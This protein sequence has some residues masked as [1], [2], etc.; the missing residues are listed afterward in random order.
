VI[1]FG[2]DGLSSYRNELLLQFAYSFWKG[3]DIL[4]KQQ[5]Q[6]EQEQQQQQQLNP[7]IY[8]PVE[9]LLSSNTGETETLG[10]FI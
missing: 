2:K 6:Q 4:T 5:Q 1:I 10:L 9:E 3:R 7:G 8:H